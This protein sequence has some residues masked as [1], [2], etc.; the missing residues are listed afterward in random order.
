MDRRNLS[1][2][3]PCQHCGKPLILRP[4]R[5]CWKCYYTPAIREQYPTRR[6]QYS[7]EPR[8]RPGEFDLLGRRPRARRRVEASPGSPEKIAELALRFE[9][10]Q[11]LWR[12]DDG[13]RERERRHAFG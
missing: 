13:P 8:H 1:R 11:N 12:P 9:R 10:K 3:R 2:T 6:N 4:R 7:A 5:L